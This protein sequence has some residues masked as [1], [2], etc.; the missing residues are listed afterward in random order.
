MKA[1]SKEVFAELRKVIPG[2]PDDVIDLT[3][4]IGIGK[5]P[6]ATYTTFINKSVSNETIEKTFVLVSDVAAGKKATA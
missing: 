5:I 3:I 4:S 6:I 1:N 2:I